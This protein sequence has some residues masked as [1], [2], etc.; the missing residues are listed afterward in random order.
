M[1]GFSQKKGVD[2]EKIFSPVV[3]MSSIWDFFGLAASLNL[4][5]EQTNL[6]TAFLHDDLEEEIYM[7]QLEVFS[8]KGKEI[9]VYKLN[10]SLYGAEIGTKT[11]VQ[12]V[13]FFHGKS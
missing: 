2:F 7:G 12:E 9:F 5:I 4:E 1:N 13:W 6:N 11:A 8:V 3:N 10:K